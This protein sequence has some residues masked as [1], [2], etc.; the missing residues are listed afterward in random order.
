MLRAT[1]SVNADPNGEDRVSELRMIAFDQS[2]QAVYNNLVDFPNGFSVRSAAI[3]FNPG[4]YD[5]YF[6]ANESVTPVLSAALQSVTSVSDFTADARFAQ[7]Q[8]N[9]AFT[10]LD[11]LFPMSA[12]YQ[13][14]TV[15]HGGTEISPLPLA[16]PTSKVELIRALSKVEVVFRKRN[17]GVSLPPASQI[18]SV[19]IQNIAKNYSVP[20]ADSY[21]NGS[22]VA[23][24]VV[25]PVFNYSEDSIGALTFYIPEFLV[26]QGATNFTQLL[27][28]NR[29]YPILTENLQ[30]GLSAQ[31][32]VIASLSSNSIVRNFHY[33]IN[34]YINVEG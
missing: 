14:I 33:I 2:G 1:S 8:Y 28:N 32:R 29:S 25:N 23:S 22:T 10:P 6:F 15:L 9:S 11:E 34:A 12:I 13:K 31:R 30:S 19:Q 4:I 3:Q 18:S 16:L 5:F 17:Q 24:N 27:I 26:R 20:P 7:M 21:Y